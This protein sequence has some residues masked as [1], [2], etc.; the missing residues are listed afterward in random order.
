MNPVQATEKKDTTVEQGK[1]A[2]KVVVLFIVVKSG[3]TTIVL[4]SF[5]NQFIDRS[6]MLNVEV[7]AKKLSESL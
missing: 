7:D 3:A 1:L 2:S 6:L 4:E 5:G